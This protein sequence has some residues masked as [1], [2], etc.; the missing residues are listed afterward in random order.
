[1]LSQEQSE[2]DDVRFQKTSQVLSFNKDGEPVEVKKSYSPIYERINDNT[3]SITNH[4][5]S[6]HSHLNEIAKHGRLSFQLRLAYI[7]KLIKDRTL[8]TNASA[9]E[10]LKSYFKDLRKKAKNI[11]SKNKNLKNNFSN[12][13]CDCN[14]QFYYSNFFSRTF[15]AFI[16][17]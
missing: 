10:N 4:I 7:L 17:F 14:G 8:R 5:E 16:R 6:F 3:P 2:A 9:H 11:I 15:I 12:L 1:M 13:T